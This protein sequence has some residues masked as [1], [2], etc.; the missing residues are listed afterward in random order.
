MKKQLFPGLQNLLLILSASW[1]IAA[2]ETDENKSTYW[3][4]TD[5]QELEIIFSEL[6]PATQYFYIST[7]EQ[8]QIIGEGGTLIDIPQGAFKTT[9]GL[10]VSGN[11]TVE[12]RELYTA[13][14]MILAEKPTTS[15]GRILAS[16]GELYFRPTQNGR[17]LKLVEGK[18]IRFKM[19][20]DYIDSQ[21]ALF[22]G[23]GDGDSFDWL[24]VNNPV[25]IDSSGIAKN[26]S[27]NNPVFDTLNYYRFTLDS[28]FNW[29]NCDYFYNDPRPLTN[30]EICV[31]DAFNESNTKV[32][33]YIPSINSV[34]ATWYDSVDEVFTVSSGYRLPVGLA[35]VFVGVS[36]QQSQIHYSI[37]QA[38][39][40]QSHK[41]VLTFSTVSRQQLVQF[42][43]NL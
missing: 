21:M 28:L 22:A 26:D 2:C 3:Q 40:Q 14:D 20:S 38:V 17:E 15:G 13:A 11:I 8:S 19:P 6:A 33:V 30:F 41:E 43:Q 5:V 31:P 10:V 37:Q 35:V 42:L 18:S 24:P 25:T 32:F 12:L 4:R 16:G 1:L 27:V 7:Y 9:N 34:V 39:I 29:I 23:A 36:Y